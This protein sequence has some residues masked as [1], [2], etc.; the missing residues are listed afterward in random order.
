MEKGKKLLLIVNPRAGKERIRN[1][2]LDIVDLFIKAGYEVRVHVTQQALDARQVAEAS[3]GQYDQV[4]CT[5][6]DGTLNEVVS[7]ILTWEKLPL[8][9]YIPAG[10]TNDFASSLKLPKNLSA[11]ARRVV[12]GE[13]FPV[14]VGHFCGER[15]FL[16]VAGFGA[17]TEVSYLTSQDRKNLLGHQAYVIEGV[18]SLASI[19]SYHMRIWS[20][21]LFLEGDFIFG[22][23]TNTVSVGGFRGLLDKQVS[24]NDGW[25]EALFIRMP[26]TPLELSEIVSDLVLKEEKNGQVHK[27]RTRKLRLEADE[28]VD[29]VLDGEFGGTRTQVLIENLQRRV[30]ITK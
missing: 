25:F 10:S 5:G 21:E 12:E 27:F 17:F 9:G 13:R 28:D 30:E 18:K 1:R 26:R 24:L 15:Y 16:Y 11:A 7:G 19:K 22:M 14:D 23:V 3:A 29:W 8:L 20:E 4:V 6:G 2:L